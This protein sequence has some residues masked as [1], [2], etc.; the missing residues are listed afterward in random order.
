MSYRKSNFKL[1]YKI[2]LTVLLIACI[3]LGSFAPYLEKLLS[4][5]NI[6]TLREYKE[7]E[8]SDEDIIS[9]IDFFVMDK[10][11]TDELRSEKINS[12][13][14]IFSN[15]YLIESTIF[16]KLH[17]AL[18]DLKLE[19]F[20]SIEDFNLAKL[21]I[22]DTVTIIN[23]RGLF[24]SKDIKDNYTDIRLNIIQDDLSVEQ[25]IV[26]VNDIYE[27]DNILPIT[28]KLLETN[29]KYLSSYLVNIIVNEVIYIVEPNIVYNK[30]ET[31]ND[32]NLALSD[33]EEVGYQIYEGDVLVEYDEIITQNHLSILEQINNAGL[34]I[35]YQSLLINIFILSFVSFLAIYLVNIFTKKDYRLITNYSI[36]ICTLFISLITFILQYSLIEWNLNILVCSPIIFG[37]LLTYY[38]TSNKQISYIYTYLYIIYINIA[39]NLSIY[40]L[41]VFVIYAY[42]SIHLATSLS[43]RF[44]LILKYF[45]LC[46]ISSAVILVSYFFTQLPFSYYLYNMIGITSNIIISV[47]IIYIILPI[48]EKIFALPT[49]FR[50]KELSNEFAPI[51]NKLSQEAPGTFNHSTQVAAMAYD[52]ALAIKVNAELVRSSALFHDIGKLDHPEYFIENQGDGEKNVHDDMKASLSVAV[53]K[54]HVK[55]GV[56][57]AKE[58]GF[59]KEII[60][61]IF[62]H[63]GTSTIMFF[64]NK[65]LKEADSSKI[66]TEV[67]IEDYKYTNEIPSSKE[68]GLLMLADSFEAASRAQKGASYV[69]YDKLFASILNAKISEGQLSNS[70]LTISDIDTIKQVFIKYVLSREHKRISYGEK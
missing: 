8:L 34:V 62:E 52:A 3:L 47:L 60:D 18:A 29:L 6:D 5:K 63:H 31:D 26:N 17:A 43:T 56:E 36:L 59:P 53:I 28:Y 25:K 42:I 7:G 51:L 38:L 45:V 50:L 46:L 70:H 19:D 4:E 16:N 20:K 58:L 32:I 69:R 2:Y 22:T 57:K 39:F 49:V 11:K 9:P 15:S 33:V 14:P 68:S 12:V 24:D 40:N 54:S 44:M 61:M 35:S 41:V 65:A 48:I 66:K 37:T 67:N 13:L 55:L 1:S 64:Y 10:I 21:L 23:N 27:L 30:I